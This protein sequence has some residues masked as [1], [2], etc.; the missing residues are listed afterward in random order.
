MPWQPPKHRPQKRG[1]KDG[2]PSS[3]QRGY[4]G[5]WA[6]LRRMVLARDPI[7]V[8]CR[9]APSTVADHIIPLRRGGANSLDNLQGCCTRCHN[10]KTVASDGGFGK[11]RAADE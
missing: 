8:L 11:E 3:T 2:R 9:Q 5:A 4:G 6:R 1:E 7:C 10:R